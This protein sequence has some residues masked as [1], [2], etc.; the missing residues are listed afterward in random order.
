M[1][2]KT[3]RIYEGASGDDGSRILVDRLWP[4]GL[5]KEK[6]RIDLW[7]KEVAPSDELRKAFHNGDLTWSEFRNQ[8][9]A[10]LKK[11]RDKLKP[12]A[13]LEKNENI[14]LLFSAK[15]EERNN[16]IVLKE[17]LEKINP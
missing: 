4:R 14:T 1:A 13:A 17:Y 8:Y 6:A 16:A 11:H 5:S 15:N 2:I 3:K 9:L 7:L 12:L 10:E